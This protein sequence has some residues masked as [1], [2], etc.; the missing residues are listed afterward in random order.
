[1]M[2]KETHAILTGKVIY[3]RMV[4]A[5]GFLHE[6]G[7]SNASSN[8]TSFAAKITFSNYSYTKVALLP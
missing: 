3:W 1:M 6:S 2:K 4:S 5:G 7:T 8:L